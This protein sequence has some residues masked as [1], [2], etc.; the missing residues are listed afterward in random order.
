MYRKTKKRCPKGMILRNGYTRRFR[1]SV[2]KLGYTTQRKG[3]TIVAYP[4]ANSTYVPPGCI[5]NR[6][7]PGKGPR[8]GK[9]IGELRKDDLIQYG[10]QY[11]L[12]KEDR[13]KALQRAIQR[14][15]ALSVFHKLD[16]VAKYS[17][18]V[19]PDASKTFA[20]DR[21]WVRKTYRIKKNVPHG[22]LK[23]KKH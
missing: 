11:R 9:G 12:D 23:Q 18:R 14:Y 21:D 15:G 4:R 22:T 3:K 16:A 1:E 8:N 19:A 13:H 7:L 2:K 10:Y 17:V 5:K 6:G 20:L